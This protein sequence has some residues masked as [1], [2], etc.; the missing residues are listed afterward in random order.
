MRMVY[1]FILKIVLKFYRN[2]RFLK[3]RKID[4]LPDGNRLSES[5]PYELRRDELSSLGNCRSI[6]RG[7]LVL[8]N[9]KIRK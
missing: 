6:F 7:G 8:L 9:I 5:E 2:Y 4:H 1:Y 3:K